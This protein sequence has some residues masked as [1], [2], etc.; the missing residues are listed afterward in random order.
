[1]TEVPLKWSTSSTTQSNVEVYLKSSSSDDIVKAVCDSTGDKGPGFIGLLKGNENSCGFIYSSISTPIVSNYSFLSYINKQTVEILINGD[2]FLLGTKNDVNVYILNH[3][4][5]I[6]FVS[7]N[8]ITCQ[9]S[10]VPWVI[11]NL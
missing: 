6:T 7:N 4:C 2:N 5:N 8:N 11:I 10:N 3:V 9:I 1:M